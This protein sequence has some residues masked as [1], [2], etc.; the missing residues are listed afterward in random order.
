MSWRLWATQ[1]LFPG[2]ELLTNHTLHS[3]RPL[4]IARFLANMPVSQAL[5][6]WDGGDVDLTAITVQIS[7]LMI[8]RRP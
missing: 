6:W 4:G 2:C 3:V 5:G 7:K 1:V 8:T